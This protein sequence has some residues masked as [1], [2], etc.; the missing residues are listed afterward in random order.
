MP[1]SEKGNESSIES[2]SQAGG[3]VVLYIHSKM[4]TDKG[5]CSAF[6]V[7]VACEVK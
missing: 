4:E 3:I 5:L 2:R 1:R 6:E 7:L